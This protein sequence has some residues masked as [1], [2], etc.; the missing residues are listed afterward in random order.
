MKALPTPDARFEGLE[1]HRFEPHYADIADGAPA[2]ALELLPGVWGRPKAEPEGRVQPQE[3]PQGGAQPAAE[4]Q[5]ASPQLSME[6][7][8]MLLSTFRKAA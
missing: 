7:L 1:G 3:E 8:S 2:H 6:A 5:E 4:S